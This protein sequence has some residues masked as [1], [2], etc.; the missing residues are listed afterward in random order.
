MAGLDDVLKDCLRMLKKAFQK[1]DHDDIHNSLCNATTLAVCCHLT[2]GVHVVSLS[3][4]SV[5]EEGIFVN[6]LCTSNLNFTKDS[7]FEE[8]PECQGFAI[9]QLHTLFQ[10]AHH[11]SC[12]GICKP[13]LMVQTNI[14]KESTLDFHL[15]HGFIKLGGK[16]GGRGSK[17]S[18]V[19]PARCMG[20]KFK[21]CL[22]MS[23]FWVRN[24]KHIS[25]ADTKDLNHCTSLLVAVND[26]VLFCPHQKGSE[27]K[28]FTLKSAAKHC[29]PTHPSWNDQCPKLL[30]MSECK[31]PEQTKGLVSDLNN[32]NGKEKSIPGFVRSS[33][34]LELGIFPFCESDLEDWL[35]MNKTDKLQ[36]HRSLE[37]NHHIAALN[38]KGGQMTSTSN[39]MCDHLA[40]DNSGE[41]PSFP[42]LIDCRPGAWLKTTTIQTAALWLMRN[43]GIT[44]IKGS[45]LF[46]PDISCPS[47]ISEEG[48]MCD[49][50]VHEFLK[51][52][53]RKD[54]KRKN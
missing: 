2:N 12:R 50:N 19:D 40:R 43:D 25:W 38:F 30:Q 13:H 17:K 36:L 28:D 21:D 47:S 5:T 32:R 3:N 35:K 34:M 33:H 31:F 27:D 53:T 26:P 20:C 45:K 29:D 46:M 14:D 41:T 4:F 54:K 8:N 49:T 51:L 7:G 6:W 1:S 9:W 48:D 16:L 37:V 18:G 44:N 52:E 22:S 11:L 24:G 10:F 15:Q 39:L 23:R 42:N